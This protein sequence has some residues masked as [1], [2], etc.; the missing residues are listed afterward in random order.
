ME[1]ISDLAGEIGVSSE[2]H[3][4]RFCGLAT[5]GWLSC[6]VHCVKDSRKTVEGSGEQ[7]GPVCAAG[8]GTNGVCA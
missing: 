2:I 1:Q 5:K 7:G 4:D 6:A 3:T 8:S